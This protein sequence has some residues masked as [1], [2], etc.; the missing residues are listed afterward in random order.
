M[1]STLGCNLYIRQECEGIGRLVAV[2]PGHRAPPARGYFSTAPL[3]NEPYTL[4]VGK[5]LT[6]HYRILIHPGRADKLAIEREW[7]KF[8]RR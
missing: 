3:R 8:G 6:V 5:S 1:P 2:L 4:P 7:K